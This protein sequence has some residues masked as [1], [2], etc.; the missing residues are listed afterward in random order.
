MPAVIKKYFNNSGK[1]ILSLLLLVLL[2]GCSPR[3][4]NLGVF[5]PS[6]HRHVLGQDGVVPIRF[7]ENLTFWTFGDTILGEWKKNVSPDAPFGQR[8]RMTGM[9]SNSLGYTGPLKEDGITSLTFRYYSKHGRPAPVVRHRPGENPFK[10]RHWAFDGIRIDSRLY[11]YY[12]TIA[13][14]NPKKALA[15]SVKS[16]GLARWKIPEQWEPGAPVDMKRLVPLF[17]NTPPT[18]GAATD[19][20]YGY[21]YLL[22]QY[23]TKNKR[24][25]VK[26]ARVRLEDIEKRSAYR[27]LDSDGKW[28]K[29][30]HTAE[31]FLGDVAGECSLVWDR[32]RNR[33]RIVYCQL[34]TGKIIMVEFD[35]FEKLAQAEKKCIYIPPKV[36]VSDPAHAPWYYSGKEIASFGNRLYIIYIHPV[37]YQPYLVRVS[38]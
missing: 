27:F 15:F 5:A 12:A 29:D 22:G 21:L 31:G 14:K 25:P 35:L 7:S 13:V 16:I 24:S 20:H 11:V 38:L 19:D 33:F 34:L 37:E 30:I 28:T 23:T 10:I 17:K 6:R 4:E 32:Y 2:T 8:V 18:F 3:A 26:V 9:I 36:T 1:F